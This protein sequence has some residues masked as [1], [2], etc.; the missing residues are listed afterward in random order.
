MLEMCVLR[1]ALI[2]DPLNN[3]WPNTNMSMYKDAPVL[4]LDDI[5]YLTSH[6]VFQMHM[7]FIKCIQQMGL[8]EPTIM[9]LVLI[10]LFTPERDGLIRVEC[11]EKCQTYY[12][13]LLERYMSWRFGTTRSIS[14]FG[15]LLTKLSDLRE[16][17]DTHNR[18]NVRLGIYLHLDFL[19]I[20]HLSIGIIIIQVRIKDCLL[21]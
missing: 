16:L 5:G 4:K 11:V 12:T 18:Q 21:T 15:K 10:V 13:S 9:L 3:C 8:D 6:Q 1:S 20:F 17:S 2:Y 14:M 19:R 7:E